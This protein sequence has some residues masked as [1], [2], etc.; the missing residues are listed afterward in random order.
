MET[1]ADLPSHSFNYCNTTSSRAWQCLE[2]RKGRKALVRPT[3]C[4]VVCKVVMSNIAKTSSYA[5]LG[6]IASNAPVYFPL[7][8]TTRWLSLVYRTNNELY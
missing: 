3:F 2:E 4:L 5:A 1:A 6:P 7:L 8:L